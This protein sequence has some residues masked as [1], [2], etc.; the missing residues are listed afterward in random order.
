[1]LAFLLRIAF[2]AAKTAVYESV[3][4]ATINDHNVTPPKSGHRHPGHD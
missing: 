4:N 3:G 1:M 2:S